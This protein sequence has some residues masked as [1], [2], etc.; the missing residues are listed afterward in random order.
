MDVN[1]MK[2]RCRV[3]HT[4]SPDIVVN[5][6]GIILPWE[7]FGHTNGDIITFT[8][9]GEGDPRFKYGIGHFEDNIGRRPLILHGEAEVLR[10]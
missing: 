6:G 3:L 2:Q 10:V 5:P 7:E 9:L 8:M 4:A 1:V